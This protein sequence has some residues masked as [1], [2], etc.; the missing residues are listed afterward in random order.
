MG[1][2]ERRY[3]VGSRYIIDA[4]ALT[5]YFAS[6]E[7]VKRYIDQ[8]LRGE[9]EGYICEINLAEFYYKTAEKPA[10]KQPT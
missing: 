2:E 7:R 10:P 9:A 5:I 8:I 6:N 4:G 1:R 3:D